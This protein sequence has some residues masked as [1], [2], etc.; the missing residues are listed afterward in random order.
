MQQAGSL[1]DFLD[2]VQAA[3]DE[4]PDYR[5]G[6]VYFV[7]LARHRPELADE[8]TATDLDPFSVDARLPGFLAWLEQRR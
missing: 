2:A 1:G 7:V 3:R 8:I 6:Q 4:H 5:E